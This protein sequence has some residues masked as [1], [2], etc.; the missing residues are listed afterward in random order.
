MGAI[1]A[2]GPVQGPLGLDHLPQGESPLNGFLSQLLAMLRQGD[3]G[4]GP[5]LSMPCGNC[6]TVRLRSVWLAPVDDATLAVKGFCPRCGT[7]VE[8]RLEI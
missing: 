5:G 2:D 3:N 4:G 6:G 8:A 7:R 1:T